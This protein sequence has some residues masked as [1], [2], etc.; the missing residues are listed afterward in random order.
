MVLLGENS[1]LPRLN[2]VLLKRE[3]VLV[4]GELHV[5][6]AAE[7]GGI[8]ILPAAG[9]VEHQPL[10]LERHFRDLV[11]IPLV[12]A[13]FVEAADDGGGDHRRAAEAGADREVG[14]DFELESISRSDQAHDG[15][16][17]RKISVR[18]Q[19]REI[20]GLDRAAEIV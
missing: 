17:Q 18:S 3:L 5:V 14:G 2:S 7:H 4:G 13:E 8:L 11:A 1:V 19:C 9:N 20:V 6:E 10:G 16:D 15:L 12:A